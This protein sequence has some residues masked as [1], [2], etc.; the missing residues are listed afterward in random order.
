MI[1]II[2]MSL[3]DLEIFQDAVVVGFAPHLQQDF[4]VRLREIG[5]HE[6]NQVSCIK[7]TPLKG[8]R[9]Y[10]VGDALFSLAQDVAAAILI[11]R[12]GA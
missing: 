4:V 8:P 1:I 12:T 7:K 11:E 6:S 10:R 2:N 9:V 3:W 5:F